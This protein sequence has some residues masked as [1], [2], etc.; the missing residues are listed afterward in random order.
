[1]GKSR[2]AKPTLQQKKYMSD[3]G[4]NPRDWLVRGEYPNSL[5][6]VHKSTGTT[7]VVEK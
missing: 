5:I 2:A 4:L 6:L 1:M 3:A 7:R